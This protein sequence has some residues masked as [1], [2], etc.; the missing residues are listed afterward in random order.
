[1]PNLITHYF[2]ADKVKEKLPEDILK[3]INKQ[4]QA[5][6][7]GAIGPDFMFALRE[8]GLKEKMFPNSMQFLNMHEVFFK[9]GQYLRDNYDDITYSY[10]LGLMCHYVSDHL[11]HP[12]VNY[13]VEHYTAKHLP[14]N[15]V[16]SIHTL[17]ESAIDSHIC[18][19]LLKIPCHKFPAHKTCQASKKV[20]MAIS[21]LYENVIGSIFGFKST[22]KRYCLSFTLTKYFMRFSV[23]KTGLKKKFF[24]KLENILGGKKRITALMRPPEG[25]RKIDYINL[26]KVKWLKVRNG[27]EYSEENVY[28]LLERAAERAEVYIKNYAEFIFSQKPLDENDFT[29][30]FEGV[31]VY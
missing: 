7:L 29:V 5:F 28:E 11:V 15:Q 26:K 3:I 1:M 12:Y 14:T 25:Y 31:K 23:D 21:N 30:N 9:S 22:A 17:I 27:N 19:E 13:F 24:D 2:F 10:L 18:D 16:P 6:K 4:P 20:K 8:L